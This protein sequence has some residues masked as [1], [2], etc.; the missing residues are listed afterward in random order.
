MNL[1]SFVIYIFAPVMSKALNSDIAL[2]KVTLPL[3]LNR[4]EMFIQTVMCFRWRALCAY[5]LSH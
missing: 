2:K 1:S 3:D 5:C 4:K